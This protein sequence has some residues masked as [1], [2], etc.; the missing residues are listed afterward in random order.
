[1][2]GVATVK[3][4][5]A[6]IYYE[7]FSRCFD[8]EDENYGYTGGNDNQWGGD[9]AKAIVIYQD[10]PEWTFTY[11]NAGFQCLKVGTSSK[12]GAAQTP[13][14]ACE[15]EA[16]LSFRVAP[17]EGDSLFYVAIQ[18]GQTN[19][20][21]SLSVSLISQ[22]A[23]KSRSLRSTNTGSSWMT[24]VCVRRIPRTGLSVPSKAVPSISDM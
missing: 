18:G 12:Q 13:F 15:G 2:A 7:G 10:A 23:F 9:I 3:A 1:M 4:E 14:I 11:C 8:E 19:G 16:V 5:M 6:P 21:R 20:E 22:A 24:S 17:W